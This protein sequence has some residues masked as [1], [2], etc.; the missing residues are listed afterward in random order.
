MS[1]PGGHAPLRGIRVLE[2]GSFMAGPFCGTQFAD[3]GAEVIKVENPAD[4][5]QARRIGPFVNGESSAFVR[6]NRNK[7]SVALDLKAAQGKEIFKKLVGTADLVVENLRPGTM[8]GLGL[9]YHGVLAAIEPRL[10]YIAVSGWGQDG[11]LSELPGQDIM[12]QARSGLMSI[13]GE[14]DRD[15]VKVGV[16]IA[17]LVTALYGAIAGLAA[18]WARAETGRG[19]YIDVSLFESAVSLSIWEAGRYFATGEIPGP[20]GS[21]HQSIAPYQAIRSADGRFTI[22]AVTRPNWIA[23]CETLGLAEL[24]GDPRFTDESGRLAN[25]EAL[26]AAIEAITMTKPTASWLAALDTA[27]VPCAPIQDYAE[28]YRDPQL[29]AREYFWEAPHPTLGR[30]TQLGSPMRFSDTKVRRDRA[31]PLLGEDSV[32][33]LGELGYSK[34]EI[35]DLAQAGVI[36]G[37]AGEGEPSV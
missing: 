28:V 25:R 19:Q 30:V 36:A 37:P 23:L 1:T 22:G 34:A 35:R 32:A 21:A 20:L 29:V 17:D 18:L 31:A 16:P 33:L 14:P 9:D 13:T 24:R 4:G 26:I 10:I 5:D 3:L 27:G 12:A 7:R 11:P 6:L 8:R 15:P 2:V